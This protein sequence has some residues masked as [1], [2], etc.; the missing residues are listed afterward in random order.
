LPSNAFTG[1]LLRLLGD[2]DDLEN[3][4]DRLRTGKPGRQYGLAALNRAA[5]I[6][7]V[8]A[9]EAYIEELVRESLNAVRP[10]IPPLGLWPALNA[11][12]RSQ[13]ARFNTPNTDHVRMLIADAVGLQDVHH[14]WTWRNCM[15]THAVQR[16]GFAMD[17]RHQIAHGVN[18]RPTIHNGYSSQLP[19]FFRRLGHCTDAAVRDHLVSVLG[20]V[21]PWPP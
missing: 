7:C 20:V 9:W 5:V 2:A 1:H 17:L 16:L 15:S 14:S 8:S 6:M 18:P 21:N 3:A 11:S 12:V 4:H 19:E 10:P 13:L